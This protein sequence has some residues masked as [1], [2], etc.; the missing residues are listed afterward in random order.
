MNTLCFLPLE[1]LL[2]RRYNVVRQ[3]VEISAAPPDVEAQF[4]AHYVPEP[5]L[6]IIKRI[7]R[8]WR[9][10]MAVRLREKQR[11]AKFVQK[12]WR[13]KMV[14]RRI[15]ADKEAAADGKPAGGLWWVQAHGPKNETVAKGRPK[16][17][18]AQAIEGSHQE[19][20]VMKWMGKATAKLKVGMCNRLL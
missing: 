10:K 19:Q 18:E 16:T 15:V 14:R 5:I 8:S 11:A 7:Q 1:S 12:M 4:V 2:L 13:G 3:Q 17:M 20:M 9:R 6:R